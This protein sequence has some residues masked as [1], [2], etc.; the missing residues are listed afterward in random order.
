MLGCALA[1]L[2]SGSVAACGSEPGATAKEEG[3]QLTLVVRGGPLAPPTVDQSESDLAATAPIP[4]ADVIVVDVRGREVERLRSGADGAAVV[5][6]PAGRYEL[7]PQPVPG[8]LGTA[9]DTAVDIRP[10]G[11]RHVQLDYDT[12]VR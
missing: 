7:R 10:G 12:G 6:L 5:V 1:V 11:T 2:L 9:P 8:Y 3:G 4:G